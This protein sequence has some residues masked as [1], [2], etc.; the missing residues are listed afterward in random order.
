LSVW[1]TPDRAGAAIGE[2]IARHGPQRKTIV[3]LTT[4]EHSGVRRDP[5]TMEL[6]L[7]LSV[8]IE[9]HP[10]GSP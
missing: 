6:K 1:A 9:P 8:E 5:A 7:H 10:L 3:E 2:P 4:G